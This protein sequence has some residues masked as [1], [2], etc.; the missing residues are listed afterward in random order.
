MKHFVSKDAFDIAGLG[1]KQIENFFSEG[2]IKSFADIFTLEKR[3]KI[4]V[5]PLKDK[6]GW[7]EKSIEN[8]FWAIN[9]KRIISLEKF[10][11]AIGIRYVGQATA[12]LIANHFL[13][14][15][16]FKEKM[17]KLANLTPEKMLSDQDFQD[18]VALDGIGEKWPN[19]S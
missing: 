12:K 8:L 13:S 6:E 11:Y 2:R 4:S 5:E 3:D 7:G 9:Q 18:F 14:Y 1:K 19:Q 17:V 15:Q 10:I 16:N